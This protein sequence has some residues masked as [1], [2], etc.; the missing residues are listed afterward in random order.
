[1]NQKTESTSVGPASKPWFSLLIA[2]C[3]GIGYL[4]L[5]PGTWGSLAG[6]AIYFG[7]MKRGWYLFFMRRKAI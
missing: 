4:P 3:F 7:I 6:A 5:A 1:M 2:T